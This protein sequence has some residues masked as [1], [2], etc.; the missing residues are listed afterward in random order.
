[1][2]DIV[3]TKEPTNPLDLIAEAFCANPKGFYDYF[4]HKRTF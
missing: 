4:H 1:M 2:I 3:A